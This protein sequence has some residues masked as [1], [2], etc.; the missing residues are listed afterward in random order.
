MELVREIVRPTNTLI[1]NFK[2][3][4]NNVISIRDIVVATPENLKKV[5]VLLGHFLNF[6]K[7]FSMDLLLKF[8]ASWFNCR[9][10]L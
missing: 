4:Y 1:P 10:G 9:N 7:S 6:K 5:A 3:R 8:S 2:K